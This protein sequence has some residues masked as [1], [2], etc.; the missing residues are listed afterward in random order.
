MDGLVV[1]VEGVLG[2]FTF[3]GDE[4]DSQRCR[5]AGVEIEDGGPSRQIEV[6]D[7]YLNS[8]VWGCFRNGF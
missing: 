2:V 5:V 8:W 1:E 7:D 4:V 3:Q 6:R